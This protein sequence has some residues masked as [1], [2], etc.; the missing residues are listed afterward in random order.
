[1]QTHQGHA[2]SAMGDHPCLRAALKG[3]QPDMVVVGRP[4]TDTLHGREPQPA[5]V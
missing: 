2:A 3:I 1:M 4:V 5:P